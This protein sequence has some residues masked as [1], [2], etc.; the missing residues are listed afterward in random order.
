MSLMGF[1]LRTSGRADSALNHWAISPE[2]QGNFYKG[3][4][5][6]G[7]GLQFQEMSP[8]SPQWEA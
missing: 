6:I 5:L 8:L 3:K 2:L 7:A 1:E 4:N